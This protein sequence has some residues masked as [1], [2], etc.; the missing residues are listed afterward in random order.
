MKNAIGHF[1]SIVLN[2]WITLGSYF[3]NI[4][5]TLGSY[6]DNIHFSNPRA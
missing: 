4:W 1:L 2:I 3:D 5:I 6:F